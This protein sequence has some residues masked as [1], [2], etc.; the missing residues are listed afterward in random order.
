ML[1]TLLLTAFLVLGAS[2]CSEAT[3][4][5]FPG[6]GDIQP[7]LTIDG[8]TFRAATTFL[9]GRE[10]LV[11]LEAQNSTDDP[12]RVTILAG[13]CMILLRAYPD[14][15][16]SMPPVYGPPLDL[17]CQEPARTFDLQA[18]GIEVVERTFDVDA[19]TGEIY[20]W[21]VEILVIERHE[22][23]AGFGGLSN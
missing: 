13:N 16:R 20:W 6:P 11:T 15:A 9:A 1:R 7:V 3:A 10:V 22:I 19:P 17:A 21:T 4:P 18:G 14:E 5:I 2:G 12:Q 8:I 23:A